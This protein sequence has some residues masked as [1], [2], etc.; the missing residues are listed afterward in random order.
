[1]EDPGTRGHPL[2][3]AFADDPAAAVGVVVL[4]LA[5]HHV[6]H[7]L[8]ATVGVPRGAHG[9][10]GRVVHRPELVE[11][12]ERI[13]DVRADPTRERAPHLETG[14]FDRMMGGHDGADRAHDGIGRRYGQ[15]G[16]EQRVFDG[17]G[18]HL[19]HPSVES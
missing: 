7:R 10:V 14:P 19:G 18:G 11:Q 2:G 17:D 12:E 8:E 4:E 5:V 13:G 3:V 6:R 9:L 16:Q 1:V 15:A